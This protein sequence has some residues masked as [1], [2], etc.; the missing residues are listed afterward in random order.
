MTQKPIRIALL[1]IGRIAKKAYLPLLRAWPG[2][3]IV[4]ICSRTP[5]ST[6]QTCAEWQIQHGTNRD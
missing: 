3:E 2:V 5:E 6:Q 4:S 1:G